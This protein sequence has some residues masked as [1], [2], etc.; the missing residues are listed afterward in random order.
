MRIANPFHECGVNYLKLYQIIEPEMWNKM[1]YRVNGVN[2]S[3][4]YGKTKLIAHKK[5]LYLRVI[6]GNRILI[7]CL[8]LFQVK[9]EIYI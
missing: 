4:I 3:K 2:F 8:K 6:V 1:L 7:Y 5:L 9:L